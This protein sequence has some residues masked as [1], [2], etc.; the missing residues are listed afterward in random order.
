MMGVMACN[1]TL[2]NLFAAFGPHSGALYTNTSDGACSNTYTVYD[3]NLVQPVCS[4]GRPNVPI[5]EFHGDADGTIPYPGGGRR[6]YCLPAIQHW[7]TDW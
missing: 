6:G 5:I 1:S 2:S 4:P 3:N 7:A